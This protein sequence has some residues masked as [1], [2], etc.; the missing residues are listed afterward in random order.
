MFLAKAFRLESSI[1]PFLYFD[2]EKNLEPSYS[3]VH[4]INESNK[5]I[6]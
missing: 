5:S 3:G 1:W 4:S 6:G 2:G